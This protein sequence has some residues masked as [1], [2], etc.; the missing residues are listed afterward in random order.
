MNLKNAYYLLVVLLIACSQKLT[1]RIHLLSSQKR[2]D[3]VV[4]LGPIVEMRRQVN[5]DSFFTETDSKQNAEAL[6][7]EAINGLFGARLTLKHKQ[8]DLINSWIIKLT[9]DSA[10]RVPSRRPLLNAPTLFQDNDN[11]TLIPYLIW[12]RTTNDYVESNCGKVGYRDYI[13]ER[14]CTWTSSQ[15]YLFLVH[16][17][18]KE[19]VYFKESFWSK[20]TI[21]TPYKQRITRSFEKCSGPLL[22]KLA[23]K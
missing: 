14:Y 19:I 4:V 10:V 1:K 9:L 6:A 11:F 17:K 21:Y 23:M 12:T 20:A 5:K 15:V 18:T 8:L 2:I 13:H 22:R 16:N 3:T 7:V